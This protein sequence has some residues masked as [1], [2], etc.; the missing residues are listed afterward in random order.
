MF[1]LVKY[2]K[3]LEEG[4][5]H[6]RPADFLWMLLVGAGVLVAAAPW[7]NIQFLGSSLTF[8]MVRGCWCVEGSRWCGHRC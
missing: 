5:F 3:S 2:S 7:V 4:S 1:F 6:N 8:M